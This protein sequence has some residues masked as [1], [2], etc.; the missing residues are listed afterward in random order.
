MALDAASKEARTAV[1]DVAEI[2]GFHTHLAEEESGGRNYG[3][4]GRGG[5]KVRA[6][7]ENAAKILGGD[8]QRKKEV[9]SGFDLGNRCGN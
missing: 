1:D 3:R 8:A 6:H 7:G 5:Q 2:G 4:G 9:H